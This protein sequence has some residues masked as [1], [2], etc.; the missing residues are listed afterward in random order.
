MRNRRKGLIDMYNN[1]WRIRNQT[2]YLL[3]KQL[4]YTK[5]KV[6]NDNWDHDHCEFCWYK[7]SENDLGY[8][9]LDQ[10]HWVCE[11]CFRDFKD[12]FSWSVVE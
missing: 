3:G 7:F 10:Y 9:T 6:V 11:T 8:C 4:K 2:N 5:Y 12:F 1:D